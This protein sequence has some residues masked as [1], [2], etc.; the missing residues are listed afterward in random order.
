MFT[1][2][3]P[4]QDDDGVIRTEGYGYGWFIGTVPGGRRVFYHP[5]D[6]SGFRSLNAWFPDDDVRLAVLGRCPVHF[7][8]RLR[9]DHSGFGMSFDL[10]VEI[11]SARLRAM[12][13]DVR[14][15]TA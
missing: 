5:G 6:Q 13:D 15:E 4:V 12:L 10:D 9:M 7:I 2:H 8:G 3:V 1:I 14:R 11:L